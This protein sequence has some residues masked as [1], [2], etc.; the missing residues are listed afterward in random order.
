[1]TNIDEVKK[2]AKIRFRQ[3]WANINKENQHLT[4]EKIEDLIEE[5]LTQQ[6]ERLRAE[7][8]NCPQCEGLGKKMVAEAQELQRKELEEIKEVTEE[9]MKDLLDGGV[10]S[11]FPERD[12]FLIAHNRILSIVNNKLK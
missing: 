1:M 11:K 6:E 4:T 2:L 3:L 8:E 7:Y 5:A 12:K 9:N 10:Y